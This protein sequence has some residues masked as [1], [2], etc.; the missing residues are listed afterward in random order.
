M[1]WQAGNGISF[2]RQ[3]FLTQ[4]IIGEENNLHVIIQSTQ[5]ICR[6]VISLIKET[7]GVKNHQ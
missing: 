5:K 6:I 2:Q 3:A 4:I 7:T 1:E